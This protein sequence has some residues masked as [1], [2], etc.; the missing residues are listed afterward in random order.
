M[1]RAF[2]V[3]AA[4]HQP[5]KNYYDGAIQQSESIRNHFVR[6]KQAEEVEF[7]ERLS[8][9]SLPHTHVVNIN[10]AK[11][12]ER[13][14]EA[15]VDIVLLF[16]TEILG[17]HWLRT[18]PKRIVNLHL[19]LSPFY[20]GAATLFWPFVNKE[21]ACVGATIHLAV[22]RVDAGG[23]LRQIR[24]NPQIGDTYY[25]VTTRLI[26]RSIEMVPSVVSDYLSGAIQPLPQS[27]ASTRAYRMGDFNEAA[28]KQALDFIG[29][30]ITREQI[31]DAE[32][33]TKCGFSQ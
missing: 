1:S 17:E 32:R 25:S 28:L 6:L 29:D 26:R 33:S 31:E 24:A 18:F 2:N 16:G 12:V 23:I 30:G 7:R 13:V 8:S 14:A 10:D 4:L 22:E 3:V 20:R 11:V 9:T 15:Q 21:L 27:A 5:K 19:G